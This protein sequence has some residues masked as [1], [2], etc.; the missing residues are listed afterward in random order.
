MTIF[1]SNTNMK[2]VKLIQYIT[3]NNLYLVSVENH[4]QNNKHCVVLVITWRWGP[5]G[6]T[7]TETGLEC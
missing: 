1:I 4:P 6:G 5:H 7:G 3:N 2:Q